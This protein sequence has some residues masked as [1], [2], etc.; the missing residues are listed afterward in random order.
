ML[1]GDLGEHGSVQEN[2]FLLET[3]HELGIGD[4]EFTG[5]GS[6]ADLVEGAIVALLEAAVTEGVDSGFAGSCFC[7]GD[8]ALA[9]PHHALGSGKYI[10]STFDAVC[11][12]FY[13]WHMFGG[14]E[15]RLG[16]RHHFFNVACVGSG[17][18]D[19]SAFVACHFSAFAAVKVSLSA[20]ALNHFT[21]LGEANAF[22][23][24]LACLLFHRIRI[25][26]RRSRRHCLQSGSLVVQ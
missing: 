18:G 9:A 2:T 11:P 10:L 24:R 8:L 3:S 1:A 4:T 17:N 15:S 12:A 19:V 20:L 7:K 21:V 14:G 22:S 5:T 13:S 26:V 23:N 16:V 6:D 25:Y